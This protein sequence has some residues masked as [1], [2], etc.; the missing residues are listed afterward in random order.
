MYLDANPKVGIAG[1]RIINDDGKIAPSAH[2]PFNALTILWNYL[3]FDRL[4]PYHIYGRYRHACETASEPFSTFWLQGAFLMMRHAVYQQ[5]GGLDERFFLFA[6]EPDLC[7]RTL[8]AGWQIH[9]VPQA[10][11]THYESSTVARYH[12]RRVRWYH[13]SALH[14]FRKRN[15]EITVFILK[16]GFTLELAVKVLIRLLQALRG[17]REQ[18]RL[19]AYWKVL[20]EVWRY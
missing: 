3:G 5:I 11:I 4:F 8:K 9:Y 12:L 7:D 16:L 6:E 17:K 13:L 2:A 19:N 20:G 10:S 15:Q 18:E 1:A 14:Y